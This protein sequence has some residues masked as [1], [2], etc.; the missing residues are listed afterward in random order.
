MDWLF[1]ILVIVSGFAI[2]WGYC[3]AMLLKIINIKIN[4]VKNNKHK[5]E[6]G[7]DDRKV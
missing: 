5:G 6:K 2:R 7:K 4:V 3:S 1:Y